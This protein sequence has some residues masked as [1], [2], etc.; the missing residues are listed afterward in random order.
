MV[1]PK[2][3][4]SSDIIII[5]ITDEES[6]PKITRKKIRKKIPWME[7]IKKQGLNSTMKI[8]DNSSMKIDSPAKEI[9][10]SLIQINEDSDQKK[11]DSDLYSS[12]D[13]WIG[14]DNLKPTSDIHEF[15]GDEVYQTSKPPPVNTPFTNTS[16][17]EVPTA[18]SSPIICTSVAPYPSPNSVLRISRERLNSYDSD[19]AESNSATKYVTSQ[20]S[21]QVSRLNTFNTDCQSEADSM[22]SDSNE[23][24][25]EIPAETRTVSKG[26]STM[27]LKE[28][29]NMISNVQNYSEDNN[30]NMNQFSEQ[31]EATEI[32][33][34]EE[35]IESTNNEFCNELNRSEESGLRNDTL[36]GDKSTLHTDFLNETVH[37]S[38]ETDN[39]RNHYAFQDSQFMENSALHFLANV[40]LQ[41]AGQT[42]NLS[43]KTIKVK[44]YARLRHPFN[45][46][47]DTETFYQSPEISSPD[48]TNRIVTIYPEDAFDKVALQ[49]E[50][51]STSDGSTME[52]VSQFTSETTNAILSGETVV[53]MQKSP[54]S[55][56]YVINK[57]TGKKN[58]GEEA[59][60]DGE[61]EAVLSQEVLGSET[62]SMNFESR[63]FDKISRGIIVKSEPE[64]KNLK[65]GSI[66]DLKKSSS[67]ESNINKSSTDKRKN[68]FNGNLPCRKSVKQ[69]YNVANH[70]AC[71]IP[72]Y[73]MV[74]SLSHDLSNPQIP[75]QIPSTHPAALYSNFTPASEL[76]VPYH[77]HCMSCGLPENQL[78]GLHSHT[79]TNPNRTN[80]SCLAYEM[81][82]HC[83]Q[84]IHPTP[85]PHSSY[86]EGSSYF[87]PQHSSVQSSTAQE[88]E[89]TNGESIIANLYKDQLLYKKEQNLWESK[90][91]EDISIKF[92]P[93]IKYEVEINNKLP[94][95]KRLKAISMI[96]KPYDLSIKVEKSGD[97]PATPM[98]SIANL[99]VQND[100][101]ILKAPEIGSTLDSGKIIRRDYRRD[102]LIS[103]NHEMEKTR[104]NNKDQRRL[105]KGQLK[106][107]SPYNETC[108]QRPIQTSK[109]RKE[110]GV[111]SLKRLSV[112]PSSP[113]KPAKKAKK[114]STRQTRSSQ[115]NV[116]KVNYS[117]TDVDPEWNP[118]GDQMK[119]K[120]KKTSR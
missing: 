12:F 56:V 7:E 34:F 76:C 52:N 87:I 18:I 28:N 116:R 84:C 20:E 41:D 49:V 63:Q 103:Q 115:R 104:E 80:C 36:S 83:R 64:R 82:T 3:K 25:R 37:S 42:S 1:R 51:I 45:S 65:T 39:E 4:R 117:Y 50:V 77:K 8:K 11:I 118:S 66:E 54:N 32:S 9:L 53:L 21:S 90:P 79:N 23:N 22:I 24:L 70:L 55:N 99:E 109:S 14:F 40:S 97:Y 26:I 112:M 47:I 33:R 98:I 57:A 75:L 27:V 110:V 73:S 92:N 38:Y 88:L 91:L 29:H 93:E 100:P 16:T 48:V 102:G 95:K 107:V 35:N 96:Q 5:D 43:S 71:E 46:G 119:R 17:T 58:S 13:S 106:N 30:I 85:E 69:D 72:N 2:P 59:F 111:S 86:I 19:G 78:P 67:S 60:E 105:V 114:S 74:H 89:R 120:R 15:F 10:Q 81:V 113:E 68:L 31:N 44:D 62:L 94:L 6:T 108:Y 61:K 101:S